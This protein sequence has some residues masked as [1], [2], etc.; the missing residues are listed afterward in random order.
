MKRAGCQV[1]I[2]RLQGTVGND[3]DILDLLDVIGPD[4]FGFAVLKELI[5]PLVGEFRAVF[6]WGWMVRRRPTG[7]ARVP[8]GPGW[9]IP[10]LNRE[11]LGK[12]R[13]AVNAEVRVSGSEAGRSESLDGRTAQL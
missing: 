5:Q 11:L 8:V 2:V 3:E 7:A 12:D 1:H 13:F 6:D 10:L 9:P 4:A